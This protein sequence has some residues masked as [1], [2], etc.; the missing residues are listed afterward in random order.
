MCNLRSF[1]KDNHDKRINIVIIYA[2]PENLAKNTNRKVFFKLVGC[3]AES[4]VIFWQ[5]LAKQ[6]ATNV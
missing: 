5:V 2:M 1:G 3:K 4:Y 6:N